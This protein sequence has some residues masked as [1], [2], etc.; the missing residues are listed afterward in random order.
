MSTQTVLENVHAQYSDPL[1]DLLAKPLK[2]SENSTFKQYKPEPVEPFPQLIAGYV[3]GKFLDEYWAWALAIRANQPP[4]LEELEAKSV[5]VA[6]ERG[7]S[8]C[9]IGP[10]YRGY[11]LMC[12][13]KQR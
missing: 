8:M 6:I 3:A 7:L 13:L 2:L 11:C 5:K 12:G 4:T 1:R 10:F 9:G